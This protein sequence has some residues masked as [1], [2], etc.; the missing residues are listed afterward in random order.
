MKFSVLM[1]VYKGENPGYLEQCLKSLSDQTVSPNE[2]IIVEDGPL[3]SELNDTIEKWCRFLP[4]LSLK[5][6]SKIGVHNAWNLGLKKSSNELIARMDTDD[7]ALS[8]R[9]DKQI[10]F[11]KNK[12]EITLLGGQILEFQDSLEEKKIFRR[13][14]PVNEQEIIKFAKKRNPFNH[15]TVMYRKSPVIR[16]GGY[17]NIAGFRDYDLWVRLLHSGYK[18]T[19]LPDV[20]VYARVGNGLMER[21]TGMNYLRNEKKLFKEFYK[22]GFLNYSEYLKVL[23]LRVPLRLLPKKI[24]EKIYHKAIRKKTKM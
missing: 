2:I 18:C 7:I 6:D 9:F 16:V 3:T 21:R 5:H 22:I 14:V 12:P 19:N 1:S 8:D 4:I 17:R 23:F 20:L 13:E 11:M 15:M 10:T 24:L